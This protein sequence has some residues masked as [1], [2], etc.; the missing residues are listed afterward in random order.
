[1]F[2][3]MLDTLT[4]E[5]SQNMIKHMHYELKSCV[6]EDRANGYAIG[7][8][9]KRPNMIGMYKRLH[10]KMWKQKWKNS[11]SGITNR[12]KQLIL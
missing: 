9:K 10:Q 11:Y 7:D 1:M 8:Y 6:F 3:Y 5:L 2:N 4:E 12:R